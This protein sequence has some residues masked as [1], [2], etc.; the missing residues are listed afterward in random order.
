MRNRLAQEL[1]SLNFQ[2]LQEIQHV[3]EQ[4]GTSQDPPNDGEGADDD[5]EETG[6]VP[7]LL[8]HET[9]SFPHGRG[10]FDAFVLLSQCDNSFTQVI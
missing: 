10:L 3:G 8:E 7:E 1:G 4:V 2:I 9:F 6:E 5:E